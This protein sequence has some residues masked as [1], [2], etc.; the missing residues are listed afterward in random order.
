MSDILSGK[1]KNDNPEVAKAEQPAPSGMDNKGKSIEARSPVR[2]ITLIVLAVC[3]L[4]FVW[5]IV[6]DRLTPS[7]DQADIRGFVV[8]IASMVDGIVKEANVQENQVVSLG[9]VLLKIDP[10]DYELAVQ[11]AQAALDAAGQSIGVKTVDIKSAAADL[12]DERAK[13]NR[14]QRNYDRLKL[15]I[16]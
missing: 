16:A 11:A 12:G 5:C 6:A 8:P 13:L 2:R 4:L 9:H 14:A 10:T 1:D 3:L 7:T 15:F